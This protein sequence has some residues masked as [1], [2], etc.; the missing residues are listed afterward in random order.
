MQED[1]GAGNSC[2]RRG[3][4]VRMQVRTRRKRYKR[5]AVRRARGRIGMKGEETEVKKRDNI[6]EIA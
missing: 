4:A 5:K 1:T 2:G 3:G 6:K